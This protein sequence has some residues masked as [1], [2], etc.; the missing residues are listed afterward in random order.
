[1]QGTAE[2][3]EILRGSLVSRTALGSSKRAP[4]KRRQPLARSHLLF[5]LP[6]IDLAPKPVAPTTHTAAILSVFSHTS[7]Q[8]PM[9]TSLRVRSSNPAAHGIY[10]S[11]AAM[12]GS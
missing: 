3:Q 6:K 11:I 10:G 4:I 12:F 2:T 7:M 9:S 5:H 1:M 8:I